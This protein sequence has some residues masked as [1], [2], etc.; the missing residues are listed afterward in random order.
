MARETGK[1]RRSRIELDYYRRSDALS[2]WRVGLTLAAI[3]VAAGFVAAGSIWRGNHVGDV[4]SPEPGRL[5]SKG[6]LARPHAIWDSTCAACHVAFTP[7]NGSR[8]TPSLWTGSQAGD[9]QCK[10]CHAG[11]PHHASQRARDVPACAECH[12]DHRGRDSSLLAMEDSACTTCHRDLST[13][14]RPDAGP[15]AVAAAVTQFDLENH[16]D[17]TASPTAGATAQGR[18]KFSH[19]RHM[20]DGMTM[21]EG[22]ARFTFAEVDPAYR[23][24]YGWTLQQGLETSVQLECAACHQLDG[25]EYAQGLARNVAG[26]VPVRTPGAYMLPVTYENDCRGCHPLPFD[27]NLPDRHVRHGLSPRVVVDELRQLYAAEAVKADQALLRRFVAPQ[28]IPGR[29]AP[30]D[31]R[32]EQAIGD[33]VFTAAKLL[34]GSGV[35]EAVRRREH[36]PLGRGGCVECHNLKP[37]AGPLVRVEAVAARQIEPVVVNSPWFE[38]ARFDHTTHRALECSECH[39]G[40]SNSKE[41]PDPGLLPKIARC[42]QCHAPAQ[43]VGGRPRGGAGV[44]CT[45]CHRYHNGD[46]AAQGVGATARRGAAKMSI[47]QFLSGVPPV[48]DR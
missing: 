37:T 1:Q 3:L 32:V 33:K 31:Q 14:R 16:P 44:A 34:F 13:H 7:I 28:P 46:H 30:A 20:A 40:A 48:R 19:A 35:D 12:R 21:E 6:P 15:L 36:L 41:N 45:E 8:W 4:R 9:G 26:V 42:V 27:P 38:H 17:F 39:A 47:E 43:T 11:P 5:A 18:I 23:A 25:D 22:G 2:R 24:R 29:T 10:T